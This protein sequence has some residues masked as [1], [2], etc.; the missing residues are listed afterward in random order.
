MLAMILLPKLESN[1]EDVRSCTF[2]PSRQPENER[3]EPWQPSVKDEE[4]NII[5]HPT[6]ETFEAMVWFSACHRGVRCPR[7][8][9]VSSARA[10]VTNIAKAVNMN[11]PTMK[12][13]NQ[14]MRLYY[15]I[16][17]R[18]LSLKSKPEMTCARKL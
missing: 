2:G 15:P 11:Y 18:Q 5:E 7:P 12:C 4:D 8:G 13:R 16:R 6:P 3:S 17:K 9:D 1:S 14:N 10:T